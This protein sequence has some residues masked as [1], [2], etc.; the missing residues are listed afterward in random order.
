MMKQVI[1]LEI[2]NESPDQLLSILAIRGAE[3][4]TEW[5]I[6]QGLRRNPKR[7]VCL[8]ILHGAHNQ[9]LAPPAGPIG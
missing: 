2:H 9:I 6:S 7:T 1:N 8:N 3:H 4:G 5:I